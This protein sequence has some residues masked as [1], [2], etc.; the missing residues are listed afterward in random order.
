M[1]GFSSRKI[2]RFFQISALTII[3]L[4]SGIAYADS[5]T[6]EATSLTPET[7]W[8]FRIA[9][10]LWAINMDGTTQ[11]GPRRAHVDASFS[12]ILKHLS[13]AGMLWLEAT[14]EPW[15]LFFNAV[16]ATLT[17]DGKDG[18]LTYNARSHYGLY[19]AGI[20]YTV[21]NDNGWH[22]APYTGLRYTHN[23]NSLNAALPTINFYNKDNQH[24]IDPILGAKFD[25]KFNPAWSL[26]FAGDVGGNSTSTHFSY[27]LVGLIGYIPQSL[28]THPTIYLGYRSLTQS[29]QTGNDSGR[30]LWDMKLSGPLLGIA[31]DF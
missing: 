9:P 29:Y 31:F 2:K 12:D 1:S 26:T 30:Y 18:A 22:I 23:K 15:G 20:Y 17:D 24:W 5:G 4:S 7:K 28:S 14:K 25:Y 3:T 27:N 21:Y 11:I 16:M 19:S 8:K 6:D 13:Y 10:Y